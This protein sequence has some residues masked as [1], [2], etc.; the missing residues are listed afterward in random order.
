MKTTGTTS[1]RCGRLHPHILPVLVWLGAAACVVVLFRYRSQRFEVLGIAQGKVHQIA[2]T[3]RGRLE[4]VPVQ[5]FDKVSRG[6]TVAIINTVLDDENLKAELAVISAEIQHLTAELIPTQDRLLAEATER[7]IDKIAAQRRFNV[8]VENT[9]LRILE[10]KV[11]LE[12]DRKILEDLELDIKSF[13]IQDRLQIDDAALYELQKLKVR[14][15][16]LA[17][18]IEESKHLLTQ[19][20]QDLKQAQQRRD[21][22][23]QRQPQHPSVGGALKV[24]HKAIEVQE[25]RMKELI[26]RRN[27]LVLKS[28]I[29]GMVSQI[30]NRPGEAVL[31]GEP[32]LNITELKPREIIAYA[33]ENQ[34][35]QIQK[36]TAVELIKTS[37]PAQIAKSEVTYL[38]PNISQMP[39]RLWRNPNIAQWG[40]PI[41]IK[42]PPGLKLIPGETVGVRGL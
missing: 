2:A 23:A 28:P 18:K 3:C 31:V 33:N 26:A 41:L 24:I 13:I 11:Q 5:L 35:R 42:I 7:E 16:T 4:S 6:D 40:R 10:L 20:E 9:R 17:K 30:Q 19:A 38:G 25:Q 14:C 27:A 21:E 1:R 22:F 34:A 39:V 8:D 36:G 32:I 29:D 12:T 37:E 15:N